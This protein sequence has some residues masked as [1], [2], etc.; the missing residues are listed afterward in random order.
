MSNDRRMDKDDTVHLHTGVLLCHKE[1]Q[2][3]VIC[4]DM[5]GPRQSEASQKEK[6]TYCISMHYHF[7]S[8]SF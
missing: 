6:N 5:D 8:L 7:R 2:N 3:W 4:R 1:A